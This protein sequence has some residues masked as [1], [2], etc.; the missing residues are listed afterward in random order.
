MINFSRW[1]YGE[2]GQTNNISLPE[3]EMICCLQ[4]WLCATRDT[5]IITYCLSNIKEMM[6]S[7]LEAPKIHI[8]KHQIV[9]ACAGAH[10][11]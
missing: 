2:P 9:A 11:D 7:W 8:Q 3:E 6:K 4:F 1:S 10:R 5:V